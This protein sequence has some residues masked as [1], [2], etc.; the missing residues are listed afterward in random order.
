M[1]PRLRLPFKGSI[2]L[3]VAIALLATGGD[4]AFAL[5]RAHSAYPISALRT[6]PSTTTTTATTIST[7]TIAISSPTPAASATSRPAEHPQP[8]R[9]AAPA[10][11]PAANNLA[12]YV[13]YGGG[14]YFGNNTKRPYPNLFFTNTYPDPNA[15]LK[16]SALIT[17]SDQ[18]SLHGDGGASIDGGK[19]EMVE[20]LPNQTPVGPLDVKVYDWGFPWTGVKGW[21][22]GT[23]NPC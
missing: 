3:L 13:D 9:T 6:T 20:I 7:A 11:N 12:V 18:F 10:P 16:W 5:Y 1:K 15:I 22:Q 8:V 21:W 4:V 2:V 19:T 23:V 14:C 17:N